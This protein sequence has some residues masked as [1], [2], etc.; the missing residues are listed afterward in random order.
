MS[1]LPGPA[2]EFISG[3][4]VEIRDRMVE[5]F[6]IPVDEAEGRIASEFGSFDLLDLDTERYFGHEDS[7]YWAHSVYYGVDVQWWRMEPGDLQPKPW[8]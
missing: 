4:L 3:Y 7:D 2:S 1:G 5:L 6:G 8:P